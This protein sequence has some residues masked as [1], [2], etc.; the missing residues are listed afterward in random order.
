M[1]IVKAQLD[2]IRQQLAGLSATQRML[3]GTLITI[4]AFTVYYA[5]H[6]AGTSDM[7]PVLD[8]SLSDDNIARM[9]MELQ[10]HGIPY[11]VSGGRVLVPTDRK[12]EAVAEMMYARV[13]PHDNQSAF[14]MLNKELNPFSSS[15]ERDDMR[16]EATR[17]EVEEIICQW[18]DVA[19]ATVV[20]NAKD[21]QRIEGSIPPSATVSVT[22]R[23]SAPASKQ[24]VI[25]SAESVVGA[26]SGLTRSQV[27]VIINGISHRL[28]DTDNSTAAGGDEDYMEMQQQNE[29]RLEG[30]VRELFADISG[31]SVT[32]T[33]DV[34]NSTTHEDT[35]KFDP[36]FSMT[37]D[38]DTQDTNTETHG[39]SA[40]AAEPGTGANTAATIGGGGGGGD[41]AS[42]TSE[43]TKTKSQTFAGST[44]TH[45]DTPA[46]K[47]KVLSA[48]LRV[49]RSYMVG[50]YKASNAGAEPDEAAL[51]TIETI[52][53]AK[54][55]AQVK[56][57]VY[58]DSDNEL[59]V[60]TYAD[61]SPS[62][63]LAAMASAPSSS[64]GMGGMGGYAKEIGIGVLAVVSL[65]MMSSMVKKATPVP[66]VVAPVVEEEMTT[67][68]GGEILAGEAGF[69]NAT[70]D[71]MELDEDA[72]RTQQMLDQVTTMVKENP[73][74]AAALVK[75][76]LNR[77]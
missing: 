6:F 38:Y 2:R 50:V 42:S 68:G 75:R 36:K 69:T 22:T 46:G 35:T 29:A 5:V 60:E 40:S 21:Q 63:A 26:V 32:V 74:G 72:V 23:D 48:T 67:L 27:R 16:I 52:E 11:S 17:R 1:D 44:T 3:V 37:K 58:L 9:V 30:K 4:M 12:M 18:P 31:L 10:S 66:V 24:L 25:S 47:E 54:I 61:P 73:D 56:T 65:F 20:I 43:D 57:C 55:R 70:L 45:T 53:L 39:G 76:W 15:S 62:T 71:G 8:Q 14:E 13:L 28:P 7:S 33:C 19:T 51:K 77:T 49:P 59:S 41:G 34:E 64:G